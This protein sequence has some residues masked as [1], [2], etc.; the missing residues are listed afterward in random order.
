[1]ADKEKTL[2]EIYETSFALNDL[3]LYLDT[4]P[5]DAQALEQF[6]ALH[7]RR[8]AAMQDFTQAFYPLCIDEMCDKKPGC[9]WGYAPAPWQGGKTNVE[10]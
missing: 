5:N 1:M 2:R 9:T 4:H 7:K 8:K 6:H 3:T 10:L